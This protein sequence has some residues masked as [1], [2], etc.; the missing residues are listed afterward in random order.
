[1]IMIATV[2]PLIPLGVLSWSS[3]ILW[4]SL[5]ASWDEWGRSIGPEASSY[6]LLLGNKKYFCSLYCNSSSW[7][8]H[9]SSKNENVL[10]VPIAC[11]VMSVKCGGWACLPFNPNFLWSFH[12]DANFRH[13]PWHLAIVCCCWYLAAT[14]VHNGEQYL[15]PVIC[16]KNTPHAV[17]KGNI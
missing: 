8:A 4:E 14:W 15:A 6:I 11:C 10:Q 3:P 17:G 12:F 16:R 9:E 1:M 2:Y 13:E 5:L 7:T